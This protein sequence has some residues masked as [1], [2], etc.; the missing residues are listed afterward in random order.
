MANGLPTKAP[1][2]QGQ[3]VTSAQPIQHATPRKPTNQG[4][5]VVGG[6]PINFGVGSTSKKATGGRK[7]KSGKKM[8]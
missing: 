2:K 7:P 1:A 4:G 5:Q 3:L 8:Y 6:M